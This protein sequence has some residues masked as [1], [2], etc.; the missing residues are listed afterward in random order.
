[1]AGLGPA[2]HDFVPRCLVFSQNLVLLF[3]VMSPR[4]VPPELLD[5]VVAYFQPRRVIVF[6]SVARGEAGPDSDID[7]LVVLDDDAPPDKLTLKAGYEAR[8]SYN[9]AADVFPCREETFRRKC[10]IVGTLPYV[11]RTEGI[12]VY[13]R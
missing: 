11:A 6:G 1:M 4:L 3:Q 10:Q 12:V 2:T 7:L 5:A 13:E 9:Q 8:E